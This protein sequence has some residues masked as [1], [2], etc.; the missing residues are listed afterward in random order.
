MFKKILL[1]L[2]FFGALALV[3]F[4]NPK[5]T[6]AACTNNPSVS[7]YDEKDGLF[8]VD[9]YIR[10]D[11]NCNEDTKVILEVIDK[12]T[13]PRNEEWLGR[14]KIIPTDDKFKNFKYD[15]ALEPTINSGKT[16]NFIIRLYREPAQAIPN[17]TYKNMVLRACINKTTKCVKL[18]EPY[19]VVNKPHIGGKVFLRNTSTPLDDDN[20]VRVRLILNGNVIEGMDTEGEG[21]YLFDGL[22]ID[23]NYNLDLKLNETQNCQFDYTRIRGKNTSSSWNKVSANEKANGYNFLLKDQL[24]KIKGMVYLD[25]DG[26]GTLDS[27]DD[28]PFSSPVTLTSGAITTQSNTSGAYTLDGFTRRGTPYVVTLSNI[29]S[30][31]TA[32]PGNNSKSTTISCGDK[33]INF[34]IKPNATVTPPITI[35]PTTTTPTPINPPPGGESWIQGIGGDMRVD[36]VTRGINNIIPDIV[37]TYF[38]QSLGSTLKHGVVFLVEAFKLTNTLPSS[39][40]NKANSS[41]W[42]MNNDSFSQTKINTSYENLIN[43][44]SRSGQLRNKK[45]LTSTACSNPSNC[46][47]SSNLESGIYIAENSDNLNVTIKSISN[48]AFRSNSYYIFLIKENLTISDDIY[49][50]SGT[51]VIFSAGGDIKIE[52]NVVDIEGIYSANKNIVVESKSPD[53]DTPLTVSGSLIINA[54]HQTDIDPFKPPIGQLKNLRKPADETKP[55]IKIIYRPDFV[56]SAPFFIKSTTSLRE[57]VAPG[58]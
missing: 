56:L 6:Y 28:I 4:L 58:E 26:D 47:I 54:I 38:S 34:F 32:S 23:T 2:I 51:F 20:P 50:P 19:I 53:T 16:R 15:Q 46:I 3:P 11:S 10:V 35:P 31:Y 42:Y 43:N 17:G 30:G 8:W 18:E 36:R 14:W 22:R 5:P 25:K 29:P 1:I 12:P 39:D 48:T 57:E 7:R 52:N 49:V 44:L 45:N 37:D 41:K 24:Y 21:S 13:L 55:A 33:T 27:P 9:W 40:A